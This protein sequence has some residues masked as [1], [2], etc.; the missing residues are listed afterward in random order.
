MQLN[1]L[2]ETEIGYNPLAYLCP[3]KNGCR[4]AR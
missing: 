2:P 3:S 1:Y 4:T